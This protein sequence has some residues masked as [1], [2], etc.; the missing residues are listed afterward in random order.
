M[1][2]RILSLFGL[3]YKAGKLCSG[4]FACEQAIR[5]K[6]TKILF[7]AEDASDNT[8]K[9]FENAASHYQIPIYTLGTKEELGKALGKEY[10]AVMVMTDEGFCKKMKLLLEEDRQK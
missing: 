5:K 9:K 2:K 10:R 4:E 8:K 7:I 3:C 1:D 6:G